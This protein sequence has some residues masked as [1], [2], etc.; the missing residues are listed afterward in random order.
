MGTVFTRRF[1]ADWICSQ[2]P[3]RLMHLEGLYELF[4][5]KFVHSTLDLPTNFFK[6]QFAMMLTYKMLAH[7]DYNMKAIDAQNTNSGENLTGETSNETLWD[8]DCPW[9]EWYLQKILLKVEVVLGHCMDA[10]VRYSTNRLCTG[11]ELITIWSK[12][13]VE[14]SLEMAEL[15]NASPYEAEKW[16]ISPICAPKLYDFFHWNTDNQNSNDKYFNG[17]SY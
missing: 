9:S 17:Y 11:F 14:S 5:S 12:K 15:E 2:V 3:R 13:M 6:V 16:L 10:F 8:N 1:E 4:V 7:D